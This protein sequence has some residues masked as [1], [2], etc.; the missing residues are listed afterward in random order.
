MYIITK[1]EDYEGVEVVGAKSSRE[2]AIEEAQKYVL[3]ATDAWDVAGTAQPPE[4]AGSL[5]PGAEAVACWRVY[6]LYTYAVYKLQVS[7]DV[8]ALAFQVDVS[9]ATIVDAGVS[10]AVVEVST[11]H[12][13]ADREAPDA[14]QDD[15]VCMSIRRHGDDLVDSIG[16]SPEAALALGQALI[17][18]SMNVLMSRT[19]IVPH[20]D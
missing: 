20:I 9:V 4:H 14:K 11:A 18:K 2:K 3:M 12:I 19:D 8:D 1:Q 6:D 13:M 7:D 5:G 16:L 17:M 10:A 15:M